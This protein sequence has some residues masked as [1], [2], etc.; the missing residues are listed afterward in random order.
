[1]TQP[2]HTVLIVEDSPAQ[3]LALINLLHRHD[4]N[5]LSAPDGLMGLSLALHARPDAIAVSY[6]HLT[7]PTKRIV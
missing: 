4:L 5:V 6:T 3:A 1:M 2:I 7:L